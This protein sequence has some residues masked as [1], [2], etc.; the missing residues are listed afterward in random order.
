MKVFQGSYYTTRL[1]IYTLKSEA[2]N[3]VSSLQGVVT[4]SHD[5]YFLCPAFLILFAEME[6]KFYTY[7]LTPD[8]QNRPSLT[9]VLS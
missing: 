2:D 8:P 1:Q 4:E 7:L 5:P 9:A 3:L 6:K